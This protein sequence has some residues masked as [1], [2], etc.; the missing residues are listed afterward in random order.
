MRCEAPGGGSLDEQV[1]L[2][3]RVTATLPRYASE[4]HKES[5]APQN[6][7][8]IKGLELAMRRRLGDQRILHRALREASGR[9]G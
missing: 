9:A 4:P 2:A 6:L 3:D 8:P 5:R 1:A 7:Y